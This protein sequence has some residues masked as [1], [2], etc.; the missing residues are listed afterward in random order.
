M[1]VGGLV[2]YICQPYICTPEKLFRG[3]KDEGARVFW[4]FQRS[5]SRLLSSM[6]EYIFFLTINMQQPSLTTMSYSGII[7]HL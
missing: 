2:A 3:A 5:P 6:I 1:V 7:I 4:E